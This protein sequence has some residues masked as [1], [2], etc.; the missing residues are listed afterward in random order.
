MN[1]RSEA[2]VE[3]TKS[4]HSPENRPRVDARRCAAAR[5]G[6]L[7]GHTRSRRAGAARRVRHVGPSRLGFDRSTMAHTGDHPGDLRVPQAAA[8]TA[9]CSSASTRT[10]CPSRPSQSALEVLGGERRRRDVAPD[11][12]Y[13]PTPVDLARDPRLQPRAHDAGSP[14]AS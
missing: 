13:T 3:P 9:P 14:T 2:R 1:N 12:E 5:H 7:H 11:D 8:S 6:V 4:I 10:R